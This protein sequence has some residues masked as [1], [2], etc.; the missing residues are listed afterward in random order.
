[1][2]L[3]CTLLVLFTTTLQ[4][5]PAEHYYGTDG[6]PVSHGRFFRQANHI[7]LIQ[8]WIDYPDSTV[9]RIYQR[10]QT[11]RAGQIDGK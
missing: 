2:R 3:L 5:Q 9:Y 10:E 6:Q 8:G 11:D 1:M 7:D 4:A